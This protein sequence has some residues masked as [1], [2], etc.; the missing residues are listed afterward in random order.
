MTRVAEPTDATRADIPDPAELVRRAAA[1]VP[2]LRAN[3]QRCHRERRIPQENLDAIRDAGLFKLTLPRRFGGYEV[4]MRTKV[5][6]LGEIARGCGSTAWVTTL[7]DD[8]MFL[9]S[10]FP[11]AVQDEVF[12]DPDVHV[13]ATLIPA[14][15]AVRQGDG[16][17]VSGRWPFNSGCL[18]ATYVVEP[19]IVEN[20]TGIPEVALFLMPYADLTIE[21]DWYVSGLRG[22]GSNTV[23]GQGVYVPPE[24]VLNLA[25]VKAG[26]HQSH[27]NADSRLYR[28]AAIPYILTSGGA[29]FPGLA[30]AALELFLERLPARGPVAYTFY[31][32]RAE[33]PIT[34]HQV[35]EATMKIKAAD[36][37]TYEAADLVD[38]K[39]VTGE[40]YGPEDGPLV[41]GLIAFASKLYM[42]AIEILRGASGASGINENVP[43]QLVSQDALALATHA[44]MIPSTGIEHYG[45]ALCGLEPFT[46]FL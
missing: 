6:V 15:R 4:D 37:L 27:A 8:A 44:V 29:T 32:Q 17:S 45:R 39:A 30:H 10:L 42:E 19:A 28:T 16:Y 38:H 13:T 14:G 23:S 3:A 24:R 2:L 31:G 41:W 9:V 12:A 35:A 34:H 22:T 36:H 40:P 11:D 7:Y 25:D 5:A 1:L 43:I 26:K 21:D 33:A 18:D 46:P 20:D